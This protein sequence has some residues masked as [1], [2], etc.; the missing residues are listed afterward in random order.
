MRASNVSWPSAVQL[1]TFEGFRDLVKL[2]QL[3][4]S[5]ETGI[6][7]ADDENLDM[8]ATAKS[9]A[10]GQHNQQSASAGA[11][12]APSVAAGEPLCS[13]PQQRCHVM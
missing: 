7:L 8:R 12:S 11:R 3:S 1:V 4:I 5:E 6:A 2:L 10:V 13:L 9:S